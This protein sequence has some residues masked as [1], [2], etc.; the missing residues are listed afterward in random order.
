MSLLEIQER[1]EALQNKCALL[2]AVY[3]DA[4]E[5]RMVLLEALRGL[6][7]A[8]GAGPLPVRAHEEY[9]QALAA[10]AKVEAG[11]E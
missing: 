1:Y 7:R 6:C 3:S 4:E 5:A 8:V 2:S 10:I 9:Q 11:H